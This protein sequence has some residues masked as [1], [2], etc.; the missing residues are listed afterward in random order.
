M[1]VIAAPDKTSA[2]SAPRRGRRTVPA[3]VL[4]LIALV[5][6]VAVWAVVASAQLAD[7][8]GPL[9]VGSRA[10]DLLRDGTLGQDALASLR[11]VFLGFA[12]GTLLAVL[13]DD[14][15]GR[16]RPPA[17]EIGLGRVD[18]LLADFARDGLSVAVSVRGAGTRLPA[19]VD[20]IAYR[21]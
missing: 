15:N 21:M 4:N 20:T 18:A 9:S 12:L 3:L 16:P 8:P 10:L 7:I 5:V 2:S 14:S 6:G 11:R 1:A 13:R 17:A 19:P